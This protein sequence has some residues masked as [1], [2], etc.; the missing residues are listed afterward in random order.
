M[1]GLL[2]SN[3][4]VQNRRSRTQEPRA[5]GLLDMAPP[6]VIAALTAGGA[7]GLS[8]GSW[9]AAQVA[10]V[11]AA[12][13][14]ML[15]GWPLIFWMLDNGHTG[16][17]ARTVAGV[18]VGVTPLFAALV[19]GVIGLYASRN[20]LSY[21]LWVLEHGASIPY[22]GT[23]YWPRFA[24]MLTMSIGCGVITMWICGFIAGSQIRKGSTITPDLSGG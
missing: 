20:D 13:T 24:V 8:S 21:V 15:V 12:V 9:S 1:S 4:D 18:V 14:A 5:P 17:F 16:L 10:A 6:V 19:S 23:L 3:I 7:F 2:V 22:Y 11:A